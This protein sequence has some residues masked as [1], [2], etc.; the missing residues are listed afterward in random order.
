VSSTFMGSIVP[1]AHSAM[2]GGL[3]TCIGAADG[4]LNVEPATSS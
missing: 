3:T 1:R 4:C 2:T